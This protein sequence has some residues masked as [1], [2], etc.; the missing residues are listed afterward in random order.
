MS[1]NEKTQEMVA[2]SMLDEVTVV[3]AQVIKAGEP[4]ANGDIFPKDVV[5]VMA[6]KDAAVEQK[7]EASM[8]TLEK[9]AEELEQRPSMGEQA[10][11]D[12]EAVEDAKMIDEMSAKLDAEFKAAI[13]AETSLKV[14]VEGGV[15]AGIAQAGEVHMVW[16]EPRGRGQVDMALIQPDYDQM[17]KVVGDQVTAKDFA[18]V[19]NPDDKF[20]CERVLEE[21]ALLTERGRLVISVRVQRKRLDNGKL[22][23]KF[24]TVMVH[25]PMR[26][27][28]WL[29]PMLA[30]SV[31]SRLQDLSGVAISMESQLQEEEALRREDDKKAWEE[32]LSG[33]GKEVRGQKHTG[34]TEKDRAKGKTSAQ[35]K[36]ARSAKDQEIRNKMRSGKG[37]K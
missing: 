3:E 36:A 37:G 2:V 18:P 34:K 17:L 25:L 13:G 21:Q 19:G 7:F 9:T 22:G 30:D 24:V 5:A 15:V 28:I 1:E 11:H 29:N 26:P 10:K 33:K 6:A 32:G 20:V 27:P 16:N 12:I 14:H 35:R 23:R 31:A 4:N 8:G